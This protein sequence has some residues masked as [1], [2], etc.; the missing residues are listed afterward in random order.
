MNQPKVSQSI[1]KYPKVSQSIPKQPKAVL[2]WGGIQ[3]EGNAED[4]LNHSHAC[5]RSHEDNNNKV[6]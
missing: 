4:E 3:G 5:S 2:K 1:S 6:L